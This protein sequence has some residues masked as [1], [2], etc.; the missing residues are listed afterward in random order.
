MSD[1]LLQIASA[2]CAFVAAGFWLASALVR[3]PKTIR[4]TDFDPI[5]TDPKPRDDQN[6]LTT[7]LRRQSRLSA[8]AAISAAI[9]AALQGLALLLAP[10]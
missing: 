10:G 3:L 4:Q 9:S 7:R 6:Q 8:F 5:G 2:I 1:F